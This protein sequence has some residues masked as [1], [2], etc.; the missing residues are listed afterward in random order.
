MEGL[1]VLPINIYSPPE[2][3]Y[4]IANCA[5]INAIINVAGSAKAIEINRFALGKIAWPT[6]IQ[7]KT[8]AGA[9]KKRL[10]RKDLKAEI[11]FTKPVA[12]LTNV[13]GLD[14]FMCF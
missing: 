9:I 7:S 8:K 5:Y 2:R 1:K 6:G 12:S 13:F 4:A 3:G 11:S 14:I 10:T